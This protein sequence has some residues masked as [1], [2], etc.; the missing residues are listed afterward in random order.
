MDW[1]IEYYTTPEGR[2]PVKEF[3]D[4]LSVEGQAKY[5][6]ITQ[7]LREYGIHVKE[8]YVRQITGHKKLY[9]IRIRDKS[10]ISRILYFAHSGK[11]FV[12]LHGFVKKTDKTPSRE[13]EITEQRIKEY[14][15]KE[16]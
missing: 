8:P 3:I 2:C 12:L 5:I 7:L 10:G 4:S 16:V 11:K 14:L 6:L 15:S 9:E 1:T 13:I